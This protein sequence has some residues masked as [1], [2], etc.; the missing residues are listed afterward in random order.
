MNCILR[1]F[2]CSKVSV[3]A[4]LKLFSITF[5]VASDLIRV[6][7]NELPFPGDT[8]WKLVTTQRSPFKLIT[9]PFLISFGDA[10]EKLNIES[11]VEKGEHY[12]CR[13]RRQATSLNDRRLRHCHR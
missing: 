5:P 7:T 6:R 3:S 12:R 10:I 2:T 8:R 13:L 1:L 9:V 4:L 11:K